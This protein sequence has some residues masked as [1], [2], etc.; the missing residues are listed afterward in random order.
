MKYITTVRLLNKHKGK[1]E[2]DEL[3]LPVEDTGLALPCGSS[4]RVTFGK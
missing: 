4:V 1:S 3:G 2:A